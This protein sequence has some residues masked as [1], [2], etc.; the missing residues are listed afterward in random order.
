MFSFLVTDGSCSDGRN[1]TTDR[2]FRRCNGQL[3]TTIDHLLWTNKLSI[4]QIDKSS[5]T[6]LFGGLEG[7][8]THPCLQILCPYTVLVHCLESYWESLVHMVHTGGTV[9][10]LNLILFGFF[11]LFFASPNL[12][13]P[14]TKVRKV[15]C[16]AVR[17]QPRV[18][19]IAVVWHSRPFSFHT[20]SLVY[21]SFQ[22]PY[23]CIDPSFFS[24]LTRSSSECLV[25]GSL[26]LDVR[27][28]IATV[29]GVNPDPKAKA[30]KE[31]FWG[32]DG[33][34]LP[35]SSSIFVCKFY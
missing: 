27:V 12:A 24:R 21:E 25:I 17:F 13:S 5:F 32:W 16:V 8:Q 34:K 14:M 9:V 11:N 23:L 29:G 1:V 18:W 26:P 10:L 22:L 15:K 4:L 31:D 2:K 3:S 30:N 33:Y 6:P 20:F 19:Y 28:T 7:A 35:I